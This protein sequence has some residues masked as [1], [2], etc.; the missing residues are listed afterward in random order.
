MV[1]FNGL[2]EVRHVHLHSTFTEEQPYVASLL[3]LAMRMWLSSKHNWNLVG[4]VA[5]EHDLLLVGAPEK[6]R[7]LEALKAKAKAKAKPAPG[8]KQ[9]DVWDCDELWTRLSGTRGKA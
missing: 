7:M 6:Q 2:R 4:D 1:R 9:I 8:K 5:T 3:A